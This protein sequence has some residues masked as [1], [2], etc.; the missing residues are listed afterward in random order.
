M[1]EGGVVVLSVTGDLMRV[2]A[3]GVGVG[4]VVVVVVAGMIMVVAIVSSERGGGFNVVEYA[5]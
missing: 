4:V 5:E 2:V 1:D 3:V